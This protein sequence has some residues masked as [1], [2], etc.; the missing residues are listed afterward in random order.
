MISRRRLLTGSAAFF[1]GTLIKTPAIARA[2]F[3]SEPF[4]LGVASGS[5]QAHSVVLWTRLAPDPLHGGGLD[6]EPI[7]VKWELA[8]DE[9]FHKIVKSGT[10][11]ASPEYAHSVHV[12][13]NGLEPAHTY[14]YRFFAGDAISPVAQTRTAPPTDS[15][16]PVRFAFA[17]CQMFEQ[18]YFTAQRHM[19]EEN[20]DLVV[21]L[22]D[23]IY[24]HSWGKNDVRK[25]EGGEV[26]TLEQYRNRYACYKGDADLQLCHSRVPWIVTWDDHEVDNDYAN[27]FAED[28]ELDFLARR[29]A[30]YQA[31]YEHMPLPPSCAP[32]NSDMRIYQAFDFGRMARFHVLDDRQYRDDEIRSKPGQKGSNYILECPERNDPKRTIL[33][34]EQEKWLADSLKK[35]SGV[36]DVIAQQ[37]LMAPVRRENGKI[38][39]DGW[40]GYPAARRRLL[41][42]VSARPNTDTLVVGGDV[43]A[44]AVCDLKVNFDDPSSPIVATEFCG[45]SISSQGPSAK[46]TTEAVKLNKHIQYANGDARGYVRVAL[47][48]DKAD[49]T[50]RSVESV[51]VP[52]SPIKDLAQYTVAKG[53]PGAQKV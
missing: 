14:Y 29:A 10:T 25:H 23:Y 35:S 39:T 24:E 12:V 15:L 3:K 17:S 49:V 4:K 32:H 9:A 36:W 50:L 28:L 19:A 30:A 22:G 16:S 18:G 21:F 48:K 13:A 5:P 47:S 31:Y 11:T 7:K 45:T 52:N 46:E 27:G 34:W 51:K 37:T 40:D 8:R 38:W 41:E 6:P 2:C 43:H 1:L 20:L 44:Y 33:G 42:T 26:Y 53:K